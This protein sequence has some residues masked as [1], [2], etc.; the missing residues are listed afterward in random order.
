MGS[1]EEYLDKLLQSMG[2]EDT[3]ALSADVDAMFAALEESGGLPDSAES[4]QIEEVE[5]QLS[6]LEEVTDVSESAP[7]VEST[8][9]MSQ[10]EIESMLAAFEA[11]ET[12]DSDTQET[13][14][15]VESFP[16]DIFGNAEVME[17][18]SMESNIMETDSVEAN[19]M[20]PDSMEL[21][22]MEESPAE[23]NVA[24]SSSEEKSAMDPEEEDILAL[25][26]SIQE[27]ES[28]SEINDLLTKSD[29]NE[30]VDESIFDEGEAE[31]AAED[32][33]A[34]L[35][36]DG[37]EASADEEQDA[38][39]KK[40]K[41][42]PKK[43]K[44]EKVKKEKAQKE[45]DG[46]EKGPKEPGFF[47]K[48]LS[49]LTDEEE[50]EPISQE[51]EN[52]IKEL[53]AEDAAEAGKQKKVK[54]GLLPGKKDGEEG[55][56]SGNKN[57]KGNKKGNKKDAKKEKPK[58]APKPKKE[59]PKKEPA[60]PEKPSKK[61][62]KASIIVILLFAGTVFGIIFFASSF[63][64]GMLQK[65]RAKDAFAKQDYF[66]CYQ[67]LY[68]QNLSEE[69]DMM[70][71]HA[72]TVLKVE[73]R[74]ARYE[75]YLEN[76]QMLEALDTL[77]QA[78]VDYDDLYTEA[79]SYGAE[80]EVNSYYAKIYEILERDYGLSREAAHAIAGCDSK[81]EYTRYLTAL[82]E[83]EQISISGGEDGLTLPETEMQ[84]VL[85]AEEELLPPAFMD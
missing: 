74:L 42:K 48:L 51:N 70:F 40:K 23:S 46:E 81:R 67:E 35:G 57:K 36:E 29:N 83:G 18:G 20:E 34:L 26:D 78:L 6:Q 12:S 13:I 10:E 84:D 25:L 11:E 19:S 14:S 79:Q 63:L 61:I 66:S 3:D 43:E 38:E 56:D 85:P 47:G 71:H 22:F 7:T 32:I 82:T 68:G 73:R 5:T 30:A 9:D 50:V 59:K 24:E 4:L 8:Q 80:A 2:D 55:K 1:N 53:E 21:N 72:R 65:Q 76:Y 60:V 27:D 39:G 17:P 16:E 31:S 41:E 28:V 33:A 54:K 58:K 15:E 52:I 49:K 64:S 44:K 69:E 37:A 75:S 45:Q 77:M 62:S